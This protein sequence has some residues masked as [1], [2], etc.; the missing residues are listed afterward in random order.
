[1]KAYK[2]ILK[3]NKAFVEKAEATLNVCREL[4]NAGLQERRDAWRMSQVS[5]N[6]HAQAIQLPQIK[7]IREDVDEVYSQVLQDHTHIKICDFCLF[8]ALFVVTG[9]LI[10]KTETKN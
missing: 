4:Y 7:E 10:S 9:L 5:V 8:F 6:Y 3:T 1:M 2:Y